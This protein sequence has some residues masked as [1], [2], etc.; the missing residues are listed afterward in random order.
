M[1]IPIRTGTQERLIYETT[2]GA[3][4]TVRHSSIQSDSLLA[5]LYVD[6]ISSGTLDVSIYTEID[7]GKEVLLFSFPQLSA[8]STAVLLKKSGASMSRFRIVATYTG[9]CQYSVYVRAIQ[10]SGESSTKLLGAASWAVSQYDVTTTAGLLISAVLTDRQGLII[11]NN[12]TTGILYLA[13]SLANATGL[14]GYPLNPGESLA[15]DLQGGAA[16]YAVGTTT[17]DVRVAQ[18]AS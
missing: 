3:G 11:R 2:V 12:N 5:S 17:I 16:V 13:E 4:T 8:P 15:M 7:D 9:V 14:I 10:T 6:S 18:A 1:S